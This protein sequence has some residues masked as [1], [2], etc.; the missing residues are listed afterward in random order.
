MANSLDPCYEFRG[1]PTYVV[2]N[3]KKV[4]SEANVV[5]HPTAGFR[6]P[7][8]AEWEYACRA[9]NRTATGFGYCLDWNKVVYKAT[10]PYWDSDD[11]MAPGAATAHAKDVG[12]SGYSN[13][14]GFYD[15]H[16]NVAEWCH[17]SWQADYYTTLPPLGWWKDPLGPNRDQR[18]PHVIRGGGF[19]SFGSWCR[20][21]FR[22]N[23][24]KGGELRSLMNDNVGF[25]V[26][27]WHVK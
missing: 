7:T 2:L 23:Y 24:G 22:F 1:D 16:G 19:D 9:G 14:W 3:G 20:S 26:A 5:F 8:E 21:A 12:S 15:M 18:P 27:T 11:P 6:L 25:R 10:S 17:D 4:I 13:F